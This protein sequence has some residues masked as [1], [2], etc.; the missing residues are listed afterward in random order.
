MQ[1]ILWL[2]TET[3]SLD[4]TVASI[5]EIAYIPEV[6]GELYDVNAFPVQPI[7]HSEDKIYGG[8]PIEEVI[9]EYN[10]N[11]H[12]QAP[13]QL[14]SFSFP[15]GSP[16]FFYS[17]NALTFNVTPPDIRDPSE[18][19]LRPESLSA[20]MALEQLIADLDAFTT[21]PTARWM[22]AGHN[23]KFDY[24]VLCRWAVRI[25]GEKE[26]KIHLFDK[27]NSYT[28]LD[29]LSLVRWG[30]YDGTLPI[31]NARLETV[32]KYFNLDHKQHTA[33]AD[34]LACREISRKLRG[35]P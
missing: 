15:K 16:L 4:P 1:Q 11:L 33:K 35:L 14:Q 7:L 2:D 30:M 24:D 20:R 27:I 23:V 21:S 34:V 3:L 17:R 19:L 32:A 13:E 10:K 5:S 31:K 29:T 9:Q 18:W 25:L 8:C 26:A 28:F 6:L 22:L 12:A